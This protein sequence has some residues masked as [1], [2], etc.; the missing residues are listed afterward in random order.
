MSKLT[1]HIALFMVFLLV[2][3]P[4][5]FASQLE[6][7]KVSD[8]QPGDIIIDQKTGKEIPVESIQETDYS[9]MTNL[10][11]VLTGKLPR[12]SMT[13]NVVAPITGF[14]LA[15]DAL[16]A[17]EKKAGTK[18]VTSSTTQMMNSE[19][20]IV[21]VQSF[22][23]GSYLVSGESIP[24]YPTTSLPAGFTKF[25]TAAPGSTLSG[26]VGVESTNIPTG[27]SVD[28]WSASAGGGL[29]AVASGLQWAVVAYM[30]GQFLGPMFGLNPEQT[31]ALSTSLAAGALVGKGLAVVTQDGGA[32]AG[33]LGSNSAAWSAGIGVAVAIVVFI[34]MYKDTK[35]EVVSFTCQPWQAPTGGN[36]CEVCNDDNLPCSEYR[37]KSLGQSC[38]LVNPGTTEEKCVY[39]NPKDVIPPVITPNDADL[40]SSSYKYTK[41]KLSPPGPGFTV[42][43]LNSTDGCIKAFTPL[44]FGITTDE[45]A[46]CKIDFNHTEKLDDMNY[47]FG[48]S[49]L[50][51]YNHTE[52]FSL[53]GPDNLK[54]ENLTVE[55][56]GKWTFFIRC[57]DKNG[58]ENVADYALRFCVDP[59]PDTTAP[60]IAAT[61]IE[62]GACVAADTQNAS[63]NFY[64]N[65]PST[66]KWSKSDQ[67][68]ESMQGT[69][70]C[71]NSLS[72]MNAQQLYACNAQL[73][74]I[75]RDGTDYYIRC[76]DSA[77]NKMATSYNFR[78]KGSTSLL[79][80]VAKPNETVF[81][82]INPAPVELYTQTNFGCE[83]NKAVCFYSFT[84]KL[85]DYIMFYDTNNDDGISTQKIFL[86]SGKKEVFIRCVDAGGNVAN[87][88]LDFNVEIDTIAPV[89][90]RVYEEDNLLKIVTV[91]DSECTYTNDDCS[92]LFEEGIDMPNANT[93]VHVTEWLKDKTYYIKCRDEYRSAGEADCSVVIK[94]VQNFL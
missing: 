14:T 4:F 70:T 1:N 71:S 45:P 28:F 30:A 50:Y 34:A 90:A 77:N 67:T 62:N 52:R 7:K 85:N 59:T 2:L 24:A 80:K 74:S 79:M 81:G 46:Q 26:W 69:M 47:W 8:L 42:T 72:Q 21:N 78:L 44:T 20:T 23:D 63:V 12:V 16:K 17:A 5:A 35:Y 31:N 32:W 53:P 64:I 88:T 11:Q 3:T 68:Y 54:K 82:G 43:N 87:T 55:N 22:S 38:E 60:Q 25:A 94:P 75:A 61:S 10:M 91:R 73:D 56:G 29:D 57:R 65:E 76:E 6:I 58:N 33:G 51:K 36:D 18:A 93:T 37:C 83:D 9:F 86:T 15:E 19:G 66:C 49:N 84:G 27:S 13:G 39:V 40:P 92:F 89:V 48:G 41:V